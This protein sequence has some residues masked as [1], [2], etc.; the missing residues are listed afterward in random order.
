MLISCFS[1][2]VKVSLNTFVLKSQRSSRKL[3]DVPP[4]AVKKSRSTGRKSDRVILTS[5]AQWTTQR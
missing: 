1:L 3:L 4:Q 5:A 2:G